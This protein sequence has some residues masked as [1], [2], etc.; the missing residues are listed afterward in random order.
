VSRTSEGLEP[1]KYGPEFGV[2]RQIKPD[3]PICPHE[4]VFAEKME[5]ESILICEVCGEDVT[6]GI[7]G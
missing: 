5:D 3:E 2:D 6:G 1:W 4:T 7:V